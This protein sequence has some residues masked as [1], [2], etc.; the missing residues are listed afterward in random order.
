MDVTFDVILKI[1]VVRNQGLPHCLD[2][3]D[4]GGAYQ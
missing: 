4:N 3:L 1:V 2:I